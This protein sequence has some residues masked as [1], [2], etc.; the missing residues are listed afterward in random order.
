[1]HKCQLEALIPPH[2]LRLM[3]DGYILWFY[4]NYRS[5]RTFVKEGEQF[6]IIDGVLHT[7]SIGMYK[8]K[9]ITIGDRALYRLESELGQY[10]HS[11]VEFTIGDYSFRYSNHERLEKTLQEEFRRKLCIPFLPATHSYY[12]LIDEILPMKAISFHKPRVVKTEAFDAKKAK[13]SVFGWLLKKYPDAVIIPE[14]GI[15]GGGWG[16]TSI[17]DMAAFDTKR[18]IFVEIK[19]END[20]YARVNKQL[21]ISAKNADE[22]WL[23]IYEA[24]T[25]PKEIHENVGIL[26]LSSNGKTKVIRKAKSFKHTGNWMG[27]IWSTEWQD[28]YRSIKGAS[29][30]LQHQPA[31]YA[32]EQIRPS[33]DFCQIDVPNTLLGSQYISPINVIYLTA[34]NHRCF[35]RG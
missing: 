20:T 31:T 25:I 13:I 22:V 16:K 6:W 29:K 11:E 4:N 5:R 28:T 1:M 19:A 7:K 8:S 3:N 10:Q 33:M 30:W 12:D 35:C 21:E 34:Q 9:E 26:S 2:L 27:H 17:V 24:K 23:A 15:G 18:M 32:C 14:F